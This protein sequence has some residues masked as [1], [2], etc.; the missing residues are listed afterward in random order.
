E[1]EP[2][3]IA[4]AEEEEIEEL[5]EEMLAVEP[6]MVMETPGRPGNFQEYCDYIANKIQ[7]QL[8]R[9]L[10]SG[11]AQQEAELTF[12]LASDGSLK[13][14]PKILS[15]ADNKTKYLI[16]QSVVESIPFPPFPDDYQVPE[17]VFNL[18]VSFG[19]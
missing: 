3:E 5:V 6:G 9:K 12:I 1:S 14:R 10:P 11:T 18:T 19:E 13:E 16:A 7:D 4:F 8:Q 15:E 2:E 17:E